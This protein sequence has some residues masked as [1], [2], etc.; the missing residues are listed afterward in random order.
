MFVSLWTGGIGHLVVPC[1]PGHNQWPDNLVFYLE[2]H[3]QLVYA[4]SDL[5]RPEAAVDRCVGQ[6]VLPYHPGQG[7]GHKLLRW[8]KSNQAIRVSMTREKGD[9]NAAQPRPI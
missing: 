6:L 3:V 2:T 7:D 1:H 9:L 4:Y 8:F 5:R